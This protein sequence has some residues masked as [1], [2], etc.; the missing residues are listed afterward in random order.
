MALPLCDTAIMPLR[1][2]PGG[3]ATPRTVCEFMVSATLPRRKTARPIAVVSSCDREGE[4]VAQKY[5]LAR[6]K[7]SDPDKRENRSA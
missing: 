5:K 1:E 2:S 7:K 3:D 6:N 4:R